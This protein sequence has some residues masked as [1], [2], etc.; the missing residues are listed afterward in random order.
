MKKYLLLICIGFSSVCFSQD[1]LSNW[2]FGLVGGLDQC[3]RVLKHSGND[4]GV[5]APWN[6]LEKKVLRLSGGLRLERNFS[7]HFSLL[8][9][10]NYVDRGYSIDTLQDAGLNGLEFHFRYIE[11]PLGLIYTGKALGKNSLLASAGVTFGYAVS[12][13][14]YYRKDGQ[15]AL[16]EMQAVNNMKPFQ[17]NVSAALGIRRNVTAR[18]NADLYLSGNQALLPVAQGELERRFYSFGIFLAVTNHF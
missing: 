12:D 16:F 6:S 10:L 18:A 7:K 1:T 9:G 14:L 15:S 13:I 5:T 11:L 17:A 2:S 8:T 4:Q 3:G